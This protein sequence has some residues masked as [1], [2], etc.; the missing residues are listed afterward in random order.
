MRRDSASS[1]CPFS[2]ITKRS[3]WRS[4]MVTRGPKRRTTSSSRMGAKP[5]RTSSSIRLS[6]SAPE[7][8][9][10]WTGTDRKT[11]DL[12]VRVDHH[13]HVN[14]SLLEGHRKVIEHGP[15]DGHHQ[16]FARVDPVAELPGGAFPGLAD[17]VGADVGGHRAVE[18]GG[19]RVE[20]AGA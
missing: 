4:T 13:L 19:Q 14:G 20:G 17:G 5:S 10:R 18:G 6:R 1:I 16:S 2:S 8:A 7:R 12:H 9:G 11:G 3:G 15:G